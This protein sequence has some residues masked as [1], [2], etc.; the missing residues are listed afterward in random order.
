M[1]LSYKKEYALHCLEQHIRGYYKNRNYRF[2]LSK[3]TEKPFLAKFI[4]A[5][6]KLYSSSAV[7]RTMIYDVVSLSFNRHIFTRKDV[8]PLPNMIFTKTNVLH[9]QNRSED[10]YYQV[11]KMRCEYG[12]IKPT[13]EEDYQ[14]IYGF[15]NDNK[16]RLTHYNLSMGLAHCIENMTFFESGNK[17]CTN[18]I[19][20]KICVTVEEKNYE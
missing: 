12:I 9:W 16:I 5:L 10:W 1:T 20:K 15:K 17:L 11:N 2:N 4:S 13:I 7:G 3:Q 18:C 6:E 19:H 8:F 14:E